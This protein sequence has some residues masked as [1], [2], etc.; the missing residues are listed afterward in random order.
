MVESCCVGNGVIRGVS[1]G[2]KRRLTIGEMMV[3]RG[4]R[5]SPLPPCE[6]PHRSHTSLA[7]GHRG[8]G[9]VS[10]MGNARVLCLDEITYVSATCGMA[11]WDVCWPVAF[12]VG[13]RRVVVPDE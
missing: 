6:Y 8:C 4:V 3:T 10:Q 2:E 12:V 5:S 13:R 9:R 11:W 7:N 1:G